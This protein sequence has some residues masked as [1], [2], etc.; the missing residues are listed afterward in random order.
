M[1]YSQ[2][3]ENHQNWMYFIYFSTIF[4]VFWWVNPCRSWV[5]VPIG[6]GTGRF[7]YLYMCISWIIGVRQKQSNIFEDSIRDPDDICQD[8]ELRDV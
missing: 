1:R 5:W 4:H 2:F 6:S 7:A 8:S 3:Y